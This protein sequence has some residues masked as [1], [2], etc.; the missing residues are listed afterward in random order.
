MYKLVL[1]AGL[2]LL[3]CACGN[4]HQSA[5]SAAQTASTAVAAATVSAP[6]HADDA[7]EA[8]MPPRSAAEMS[9]AMLHQVLSDP[10][11]DNAAKALDAERHPGQ[12]LAFFGLRPD[13]SVIE[14]DP[15][16]GWYATVLAPLLKQDG[17]YTA[18]MVSPLN[19]KRAAT[20]MRVLRKRFG[21]DR[22]RFARARLSSFDPH[23]PNLG[24]PGSADMVL[25]FRDVHAWVARGTA[26]AMFRAIYDVLKPGGVFGVVDYRA[27]SD[28]GADDSDHVAYLRHADVVRLAAQAGFT[29]DSAS[30][31]NAAV[32]DGGDGGQAQSGADRMTL[33]FVK[34][35]EPKHATS[36]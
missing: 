29:L 7:P 33:R 19:G 23:T 10:A 5:T 9:V 17:T 30:D 27:P 22:D 32:A 21:A 26:A 18:A 6:V 1:A 35:V 36:V 4:S 28:I 25:S 13:M 3:L 20:N 2:A 8:V 11:R 16:K 24:T 34:P 12:T 31:I 14:V 15:G